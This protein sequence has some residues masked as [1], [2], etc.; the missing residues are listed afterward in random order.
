MGKAYARSYLFHHDGINSSLPPIP[1]EEGLLEIPGFDPQLSK[2]ILIVDPGAR[3]ATVVAPAAS[4]I[5]L[6][7]PAIKLLSC[8]AAKF[9]FVTDQGKVLSNHEPFLLLRVTPG[10]TATRTVKQDQPVWADSIIW[11]N[12]VRPAKVPKTDADGRVTV[13]NLI[14]G[15]TYRVSFV[16]K[17]GDFDEGYEFTV[18]SGE[19]V[20]V[21]EVVIPERDE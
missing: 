5:D 14:P 16:N 13:D 2:P 17:Q 9:R 18:R 11:Q 10:A 20:D 1:L 19:T 7:S 6:S 4:E 8:G 12:I 15:A 21:G 3:C